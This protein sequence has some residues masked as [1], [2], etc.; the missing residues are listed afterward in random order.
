MSSG[1][2]DRFTA[3]YF[4]YVLYFLI[5]LQMRCTLSLLVMVLNEGR[6]QRRLILECAN[7][8]TSA[9]LHFVPSPL[10]RAPR[11]C[12]MR[13]RSKD[14]WERVVLKEFTDEDWRM[15][16]RMTRRSF[17]KLCGLM[18]GVLRP[19][20]VT[21]RAPI[22]LQ[23]RVAIVLYK[24]VSCAE[25][26]TIAKQFGVHKTTVK[27][28]VYSFSKG[29][30]SNVIN[31]LI[32]LPTADEARAI[33]RGFE[34]KFDIP[35][36]VG[37]I[38]R[39]HIPVLPPSDGYKDFVNRKGWPSYVLQAVVDHTYRFWNINC[40]MPGCTREADVLRQSSLFDQAH[41]LPKVPREIGGNSVN[42]FILGGPAYP[43]MDWLIRAHRRP[44]RLTPEQLQFNV[45]LHSARSTAETAFRRLKSRWKVLLKKS[46]FHYTFTPY[47]IATCCALHNF[48]ESEE[49]DVDPDWTEEAAVLERDLPQPDSRSYDEPECPDGRKIRLALTEYLK[50]NFPLNAVS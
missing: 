38:D 43:L 33:A 35:Q 11:R 7:N 28:F 16:F 19:Q 9:L 47:V 30:V 49:E 23:M 26:S 4:S 13:V 46:V 5:S 32:K 42:F 39:T 48:C 44:P 12:W 17:D 1:E 8:E 3:L 45:R 18:E 27:K 10:P 22:P 34:E 36:V 25:Y 29:M 40:K 15:T 20:D 14:W 41:L 24:L 21:V 31:D 37:F 50:T 2:L 6:R